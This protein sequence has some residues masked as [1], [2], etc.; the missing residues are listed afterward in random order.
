MCLP[1]SE[2]HRNRRPRFIQK[3][4]LVYAIHH[5]LWYLGRPL[6]LSP[7]N[8]EIHTL[9]TLSLI[10]ET[11]FLSLGEQLFQSLW[12]IHN[13]MKSKTTHWTRGLAE[14]QHMHF[15]VKCLWTKSANNTRYLKLLALKQMPHTRSQNMTTWIPHFFSCSCRKGRSKFSSFIPWFPLV[16]GRHE[17]Q[18]L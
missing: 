4:K 5:I 10:L 15:V 16:S 13:L 18:V 17:A 8:R 1:S 14:G 3:E 11:W 9:K 12:V 6:R 2:W 7:F